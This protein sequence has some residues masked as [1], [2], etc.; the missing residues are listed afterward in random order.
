MM[1]DVDVG[2]GVSDFEELDSPPPKPKK[3]ATKAKT[4]Q[5]ATKTTAKTTAAK[6]KGKAA[7]VGFFA[8]LLVAPLLTA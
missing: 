8:P 6:R 1:V 5:A 7:Q 3:R 4:T 2:A